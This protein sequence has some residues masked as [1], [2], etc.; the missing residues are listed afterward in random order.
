MLFTTAP[1]KLETYAAWGGKGG[2]SEDRTIAE[3][4]VCRGEASVHY[5]IGGSLALETTACRKSC[6][7]EYRMSGQ[8]V[9]LNL[10]IRG[11]SE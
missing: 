6:R 8:L 4:E 1:R 3:F 10:S 2:E 11:P 7:L 9:A 5:S